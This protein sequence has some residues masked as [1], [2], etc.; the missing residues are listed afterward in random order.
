MPFWLVYT[1][2]IYFSKYPFIIIIRSE[3]EKIELMSKLGIETGIKLTVL[4]KKKKDILNDNDDFFNE[5][6]L[7]TNHEE[8]NDWRNFFS[9]ENLL[10]NKHDDM[11]IYNAYSNDYRDDNKVDKFLD[12]NY[13]DS[14]RNIDDKDPHD[15]NKD[16]D[17]D[18]NFKMFNNRKDVNVDKIINKIRRKKYSKNPGDYWTETKVQ[19]LI[20]RKFV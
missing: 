18:E 13:I 17:K 12:H 1:D 11:N 16:K 5:I 3:K 19:E 2:L 4:K 9:N 14:H 8:A 7:K 10:S 20:S 15:D 6:I